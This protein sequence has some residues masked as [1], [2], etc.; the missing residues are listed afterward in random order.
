MAATKRNKR[1]Y[2]AEA[3]KIR[4]LPTFYIRNASGQFLA[5]TSGLPYA[6]SERRGLAFLSRG[7]AEATV[8]RRFVGLAAA[9]QMGVRVVRG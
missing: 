4:R 7:E 5:D 9:S 3:K 2:V 6:W 8:R 1:R